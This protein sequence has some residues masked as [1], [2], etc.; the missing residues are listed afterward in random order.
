MHFYYYSGVDASSGV[1]MAVDQHAADERIRFEKIQDEWKAYVLRHGE[2]PRAAVQFSFDATE[3][4]SQLCAVQ[5]NLLKFWGWTISLHEQGESRGRRCWVEVR[6]APV[7]EK[8]ILSAHI[9]EEFLREIRRGGLQKEF[10]STIQKEMES[11]ACRYAIMFGDFLSK[12]ECEALLSRL[13]RCR[14]PFQ[15]LFNRNSQCTRTRRNLQKAQCAH[16]RPSLVPIF[17]FESL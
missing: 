14:N 8:R 9:F 6:T 17:K 7:I 15:V 4:L 12:A 2:A 3:E 1:L 5:L 13:G 10:S 11:V 16:G